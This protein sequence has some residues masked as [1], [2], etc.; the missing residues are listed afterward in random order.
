[1]NEDD[2]ALMKKHGTW[3]VPTIIAGK[4]VS[5][6][7]K[8]PG[9][10]PTQVAAKA[11]TVGPIIEATAGKAYKAGVKI[12]FGTDASV[13]PHGDNAKEFGYMVEAGIPPM[14]AIQAATMHAAELLKHDKD[15]GSVTA[16][17]FAD[18]V[19]VPGNPIDDISLMTRVSFV[20]KEGVVYKR[21]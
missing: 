15:L 11:S 10:Y 18:V 6:K 8:V 9:Y 3:Y 17:K 12:A 20:M 1:M 16:G 4:F 2:M 14:Y 13:Y 21:P 5:E 19:A 7:A